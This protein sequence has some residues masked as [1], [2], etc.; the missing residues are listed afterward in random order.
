MIMNRVRILRMVT[1]RLKLC[2][3]WLGADVVLS[4]TTGKLTA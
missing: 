3:R 4:G 2:E 1:F